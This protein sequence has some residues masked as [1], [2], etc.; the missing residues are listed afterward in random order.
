MAAPSALEPSVAEV[1][2][3]QFEA[4]RFDV[5]KTAVGPYLVT[6]GLPVGAFELAD[7]PIVHRM[8]FRLVPDRKSEVAVG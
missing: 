1:V 8:D 4:R 3:A 7:G 6:F 2:V 5:A